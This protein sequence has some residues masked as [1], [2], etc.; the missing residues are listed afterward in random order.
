MNNFFAV[1]EKTILTYLE[2]HK[3]GISIGEAMLTWQLSGGHITKLV[4][5]LKK[6]GHEID[7]VFERNESGR[8]YARYFLKAKRMES[9]QSVFSF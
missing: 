3:N 8:R 9:G 5:N 7:R 4:S 2:K 6:Q 1:N